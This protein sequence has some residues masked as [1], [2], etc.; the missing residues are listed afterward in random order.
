MREAIDVNSEGGYVLTDE[1]STR[2]LFE[3]RGF[4]LTAGAILLMTLQFQT[5]PLPIEAQ[6]TPLT[7][8]LSLLLLPLCLTGIRKSPLLTLVTAFLVY[9][10][11]HSVIALFVEMF[12]SNPTIRFVSWFRQIVAVGTG[13][14]TYLV[15][16]SMLLGMSNRQMVRYMLIGA[17]PSLML[18][19]LNIL[20]GAMNQAWAGSIILGIRSFVAPL[21][22]TSPVRATGF[23]MEPATYATTLV[24]TVFP[25]MLILLGEKK[26]SVGLYVLVVST[27]ACFAWTFSLT[28]VI[29]LGTVAFSGLFL[30]PYRSLL[31]K[32]SLVLLVLTAAVLTLMPN[33]QIMSHV[34]TLSSGGENVS[35]T[36]RF[37]S[38]VGPFQAMFSS[39]TMLGYGLGGTATH[40]TELI[41][42]AVQAEILAVKWKELP[43]LASLPGRVFAEG[44]LI[45]IVLLALLFFF[46]L[47]TLRFLIRRAVSQADEIFLRSTR[48][49]VIAM[50][51]SV[52]IGLGS[53]HNPYLWFWIAVVDVQYMRFLDRRRQSTAPAS[54]RLGFPAI[55][56]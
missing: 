39:W 5:T 17:I 13:A 1:G 56:P 54:A 22:Y 53:Y 18:G 40:F 12:F 19:L 35:F 42:P 38:F 31:L 47:W 6:V 52:A 2:I 37:Y 28:G 11:L 7:A 43:N 48:L 14:A 26:R 30:G 36:D 9:L 34:V 4:Q 49:A 50:Y 32:M 23:S 24:L 20:W 51:L 45:G 44:G 15:L 16:R 8:V 3:K 10:T 27:M 25:M 55:S 33:N 46:V 21:G 41:P 29:L